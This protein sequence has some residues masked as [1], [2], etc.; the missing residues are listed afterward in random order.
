MAMSTI[1]MSV[2]MIGILLIEKIRL[3]GNASEGH[4]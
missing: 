3:S 1:L 4:F 2:T